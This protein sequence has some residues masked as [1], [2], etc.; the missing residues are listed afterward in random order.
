MSYERR[1]VIFK[2]V[3]TTSIPSLRL[4]EISIPGPV[5]HP[6]LA[7]DAMYR[8]RILQNVEL[9]L[10]RGFFQNKN[11]AIGRFVCLGETTVIERLD[12]Q[13]DVA[14]RGIDGAS[15]PLKFN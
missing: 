15:Q 13:L 5:D 9:S 12:V 1:S 11:R 8:F 4:A 7:E 14:V 10:W 3:L 6:S 2:A